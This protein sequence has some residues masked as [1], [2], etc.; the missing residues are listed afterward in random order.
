MHIVK[1]CELFGVGFRLFSVLSTFKAFEYSLYYMD[2]R[3]TWTT[4]TIT[5]LGG[6]VEGY[7]IY[8]VFYGLAGG[9]GLTFADSIVD[10]LYGNQ[11]SHSDG[12]TD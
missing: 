11:N 8:V 10:S 5:T 2:A 6:T 3:L 7:L 9:I 12:E 4:N 1:P